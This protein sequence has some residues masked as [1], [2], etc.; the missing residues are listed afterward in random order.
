R[1][2]SDR[3]G[4]PVV[5]GQ[6]DLFSRHEFR[7]DLGELVLGFLHGDLLH[8]HSRVSLP[9]FTLMAISQWLAARI[10][11]RLVG[12]TIIDPAGTLICG[13]FHTNQRKACVSSSRSITC[14][15]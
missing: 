11:L 12:S 8:G 15:P 1:D 9:M 10:S 2:A 6:Y 7:E 3:C 4:W 13:S 14:T 5:T